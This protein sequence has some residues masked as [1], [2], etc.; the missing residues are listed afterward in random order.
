MNLKKY[1]DFIYKRVPFPYQNAHQVI[2][3]MP[4]YLQGDFL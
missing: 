3:R 1:I 2:T 4:T